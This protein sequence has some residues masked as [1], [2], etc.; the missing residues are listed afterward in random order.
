M[1]RK[2]IIVL[3]VTVCCALVSPLYGLETGIDNLEMWGYV[4]NE[5]AFHTTA[6]PGTAPLYKDRYVSPLTGGTPLGHPA[7]FAINGLLKE[8]RNKHAGS[9]MKFENTFN[10]KALYRVI[11]GRLE[12]F[13]RFYLLFDS[14]YDIEDYWVKI[15]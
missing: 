13:G 3:I 5:I 12:I 9:L 2:M 8:N 4:Q 1:V 10:L 7:S 6:N 14:V 11:P 15:R